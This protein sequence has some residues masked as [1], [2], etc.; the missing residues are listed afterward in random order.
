MTAIHITL[1]HFDMLILFP[2]LPIL[3]WTWGYVRADE[4]V[5]SLV[6]TLKQGQRVRI[7]GKV[8]RV[9]EGGEV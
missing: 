5:K 3:L 8:F 7:A 9:E 4:D 2:I 1:T 6:S